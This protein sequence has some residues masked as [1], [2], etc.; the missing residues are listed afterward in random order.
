MRQSEM[1][2]ACVAPSFAPSQDFCDSAWWQ[3]NALPLASDRGSGWLQESRHPGHD[4]VDLQLRF[5]NLKGLCGSKLL[6]G[7]CQLGALGNPAPVTNH[8]RCDW[9]S[10]QSA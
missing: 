1:Q 5:G 10:R 6:V 9:C 3:M 2:S 4:I 7:A 8:L